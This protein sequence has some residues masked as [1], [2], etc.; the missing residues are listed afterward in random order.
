ME[1]LHNLALQLGG[2]PLPCKPLISSFLILSYIGK[3]FTKWKRQRAWIA[4][5]LVKLHNCCGALV[6]PS[7]L[8]MG[9]LHCRC[10][11]GHQPSMALLQQV[12][13]EWGNYWKKKRTSLL[14]VHGHGFTF[15]FKSISFHSSSK[16]VEGQ[17]MQL[18]FTFIK[19]ENNTHPSYLQIQMVCLFNFILYQWFGSF[20]CTLESSRSFKPPNVDMYIC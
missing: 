7:G 6:L 2:I 19:W 10:F 13:T 11:S 15:S 14:N 17:R 5:G 4:H 16:G 3:I 9:G 1:V 20:V 8:E 12:F 18:F